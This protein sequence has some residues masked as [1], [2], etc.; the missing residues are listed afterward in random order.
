M[1]AEKLTY[2]RLAK[3]L[4][5]TPVAAFHWVKNPHRLSLIKISR[6]SSAI[7]IKKETVVDWILETV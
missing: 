4:G 7:K 1:K 3:I 5:I 6:L 2:L